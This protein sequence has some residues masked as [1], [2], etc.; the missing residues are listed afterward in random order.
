MRRTVTT[1]PTVRPLAQPAFGQLPPS[2][3]GHVLDLANAAAAGRY[4]TP[5]GA[6]QYLVPPTIGSGGALPLFQQ[7]LGPSMT[8]IQQMQ[9]Q[10]Q[11]QQQQR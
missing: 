5:A 10:R 4:G 6:P 11:Q 8:P 7:G 9:Q 3:L 2:S 1:T